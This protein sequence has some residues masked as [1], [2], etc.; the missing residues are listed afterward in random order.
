VFGS[1]WVINAIVFSSVL[2]TIFIANLMVMR[3]K[4]P[5]IKTAWIGLYL[6]ILVNFFFPLPWLFEVGTLLRIFICS[7]LIGTPVF[8][9]AVCFSRLFERETITGYPLGI[10]LIGAMAGGIIEYSSMAVGMRKVWLII[11]AIYIL[12]WL[13]TSLV[14][15]QKSCST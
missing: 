2:L 15:K 5:S 13:S 3:K 12:A 1:T 7:L 4:A 14:S 6:F 8:F 11:L 9:A 10:N